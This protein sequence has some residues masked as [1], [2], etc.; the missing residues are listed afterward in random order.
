MVDTALAALQVGG[1]LF[2]SHPNVKVVF[3]I[4]DDA[5]VAKVKRCLIAS[6]FI[7]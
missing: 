3:V 5:P 6:A 7:R 4:H 1:C 2:D